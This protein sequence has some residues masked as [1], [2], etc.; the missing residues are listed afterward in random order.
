MTKRL[1]L[2]LKWT[3]VSPCSEADTAALE[4]ELDAE[5]TRTKAAAVALDGSFEVGR[6][7]LTLS[8]PH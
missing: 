4:S 5:R 2:S 8:N 6:C 3:S 7:R 1:R